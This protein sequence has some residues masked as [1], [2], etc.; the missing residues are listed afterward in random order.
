LQPGQAPSRSWYLDPV[1][2]QQK[3]AVFLSWIRRSLPSASLDSILKTDLFEEANGQDRILHALVP[4]ARRKVGIDIDEPTVHQAHAPGGEFLSLCTD[5]R[6]LPFPD[7]AFDLIVSTSTL[8]HFEV[9]ADLPRALHELIRVLRPGGTLLVIL[10][11]PLNP[12]YHPLKWITRRGLSPFRLGHTLSARALT[13]ELRAAGLRIHST[14]YLIHNPRLLSTALFL[15]VRTLLGRHASPVIGA[16]LALF[17]LLGHLPTRCF[18]GCF[19]A[20]AARK[21]NAD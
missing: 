8:D 4:Q 6:S 3:G 7:G 19:S 5:V 2:A 17:E 14:A 11:N 10:D 9:A 12:L 18:T 13:A 20:V 16:L 1:V 21:P 15:G